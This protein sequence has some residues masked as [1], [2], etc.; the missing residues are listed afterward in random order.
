MKDEKKHWNKIASNYNDEIFD[1]FNSDKHGKIPYYIK[2]YSN[3]K[4]TA[5][6]FGCGNGK[7]F[8]LL[9]PHFKSV[10]GI[11]ISQNLINQA[12]KRG[13]KN[14]AFQT[15]DLSISKIKLPQVDFI[16]SCNVIMLPSIEKNY[17]MFSNIYDAL[18]PGGNAVIVVPSA[19]SAAF[20]LW[21]LIDVYKKEGVKVKDIPN[22]ELELFAGTKKDIIQG[23]LHI[24]GVPTKH[25]S[26]SEL[27]VILEDA[28]LKLT[29]I[30]KVN[31]TWDTELAEQPKWL[32]APYPWDWII[33]CKRVK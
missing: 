2:K 30:D 17:A 20:A 3:K 23:I 7:S 18:K 24:D 11:D 14:V 9:A 4:H 33:E 8:P 28:G 32:K 10:I 5:I 25:Y 13:F 31:Y 26:E 22:N 15:L 19:E 29:K 21:R 16:F 6:D 1:V 12:K 27:H